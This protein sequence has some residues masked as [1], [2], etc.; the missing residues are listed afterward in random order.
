[1]NS[2]RLKL[3][4]RDLIDACGGLTEAS[5]ACRYSAPQLS[6]CQNPEL[7]DFLAIDVLARLE[8]YCGKP[9]ISREM[10]EGEGAVEAPASLIDEA[11][12]VPEAGARLQGVVRLITRDGKLTPR[13][14]DQGVAAA[15]EVIDQAREVITAL[16][17]A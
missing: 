17:R 10:A 7:P 8:A 11:M 14:R 13:E 1:M 4:T 3:L 15:L 9:V 16:E 12:D 5:A 2:R 6:R